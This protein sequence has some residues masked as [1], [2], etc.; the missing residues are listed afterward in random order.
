MK[1]A[2]ANNEPEAQTD[3]D[4]RTTL[5]STWSTQE[6]PNDEVLYPNLGTYEHP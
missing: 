5:D 1:R 6:F 3:D 4:G 2:E